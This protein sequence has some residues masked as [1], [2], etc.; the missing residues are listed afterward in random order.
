MD[1]QPVPRQ[2]VRNLSNR[3]RLLAPLHTDINLRPNQVKRRWSSL[4][5]C[6]LASQTKQNHEQHQGNSPHS[7]I[8]RRC[9]PSLHSSEQRTFVSFEPCFYIRDLTGPCTGQPL[10]CTI[11]YTGA[12]LA[13]KCFLLKVFST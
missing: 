2:K 9:S 5:P 13:W 6:R 4:T 3:Q 8:V 11:V 10:S 1:P 12:W 7:S